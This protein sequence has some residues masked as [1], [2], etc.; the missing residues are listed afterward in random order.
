[1]I[2]VASPADQTIIKTA[3][4]QSYNFPGIYGETYVMGGDKEIP[5]LA[6]EENL[7]VIGHGIEKGG[8]GVAEIGD[9]SGA[10]AV[11][12]LELWDNLKAIFP[13]MY[14]GDIFVDACKSAN[15][16]E[17]NFSLIEVL[18]TQVDVAFTDVDV[19]GRYGDVGGPIPG[20]TEEGWTR[21]AV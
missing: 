13:D 4:N 2:I 10:F 14:S 20:P 21:P 16:A 19:F 3:R 15:F 1:M 8:S 11:D 18:K 7:F 12:G 17:D 5:K 9:A 6:P